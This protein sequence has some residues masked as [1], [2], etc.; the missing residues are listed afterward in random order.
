MRVRESYYAA[1]EY[2]RRRRWLRAFSDAI[3]DLPKYVLAFVPDEP[4]F[5]RINQKQ[6]DIIKLEGFEEEEGNR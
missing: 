1:P 2:Y 6:D 5:L 4:P 3:K